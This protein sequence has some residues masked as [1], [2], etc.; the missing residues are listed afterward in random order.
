MS[1]LLFLQINLRN[2]SHRFVVHQTGLP[3]PALPL[4]K[5]VL[6]QET[7][8]MVSAL[9]GFLVTLIYCVYLCICGCVGMC[10]RACMTTVFL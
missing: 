9:A 10:V 2:M 6:E 4:G 1:L 8:E 5:Q 7:F 3:V